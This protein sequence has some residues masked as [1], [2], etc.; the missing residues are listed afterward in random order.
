MLV[1]YNDPALVGGAG[2]DAR[3]SPFVIVVRRAGVAPLAHIVNASICIAI[4]SIAC[5]CVYAGSRTLHAL[6]EQGYAPKAFAYV[7][8]AGRPLFATLFVC[9]FAPIAY[10]NL[11]SV[12]GQTF[13]WLLALSGLSTLFTWGSICMSHIRF[14][15]AWKVQGHHIDEI[16]FQAAMGT[17]GSWI[18]LVLIV[19]VLIAQFYIA[20]CPIDGKAN[21]ADFFKSYL[22]LPVVV[23]MYA[24]GYLW[25]REKFKRAHEIDL[26]SGRK[27]WDT[28]EEL[29]AERA[30]LRNR[31]IHV[32]IWHFLF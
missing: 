26:V 4:M 30:R 10:I 24:A 28:A 27:V 5:S 17:L 9:A 13:D 15:R 7:D 32:R 11:S 8:K 23:I 12:G 2:F 20:V 25:K 16:P 14:R 29:N 31:P 3:L 19:L 18:A 1:P 21:A 6:G 22:A